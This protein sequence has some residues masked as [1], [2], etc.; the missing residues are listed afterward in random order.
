MA[1]IWPTAA[2]TNHAFSK[3]LFQIINKWIQVLKTPKQWKK[4]S[5]VH[6]LHQEPLAEESFFPESHE[7]FFFFNKPLRKHKTL[8]RLQSSSSSD[9]TARCHTSPS[10]EN[11][12]SMKWFRPPLREWSS[13]M[14]KLVCI[15]E[16]QKD[17]NNKIEA[18]SK[19]EPLLSSP[20]YLTTLLSIQ[21]PGE[22]TFH[23]HTLTIMSCWYP[24]DTMYL[25]LGENATQATP[26]LCSWSSA[27][28]VRSATS[29]TRT[30][31][32]C[33][34]WRGQQQRTVNVTSE[35][36]SDRFKNT[37]REGGL[38]KDVHML[39]LQGSEMWD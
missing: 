22:L 21:P 5:Q 14:S 4:M 25:E 26:Y 18:G 2:F 28:W 13:V 11:T 15:Y 39:E 20:F 19:M 10:I 36:G 38:E 12:P 9:R 34:L 27:T 29:H 16:C 33:P 6:P 23:D 24:T 7:L 37:C 32:M 30:A 35:V 17:N 31:G 3:L 1:D 8:S